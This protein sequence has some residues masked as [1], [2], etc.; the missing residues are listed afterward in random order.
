M[1]FSNE[2]RLLMENLY[3][4]KGYGAKRLI[5]EFPNKDW[6][7]WGLNKLLKRLQET[8]MTAKRNGSIESI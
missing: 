4:L 2:D 6:G 8:G 5:N 7:L 3:I 1:G